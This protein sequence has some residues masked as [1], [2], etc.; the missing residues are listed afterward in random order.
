MELIK[1]KVEFREVLV[2]IIQIK[3]EGVHLILK[4]EVLIM[5]ILVERK[6]LVQQINFEIKISY[7]NKKNKF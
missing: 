3:D 1:E 5:E 4:T 6:D 2:K 7:F